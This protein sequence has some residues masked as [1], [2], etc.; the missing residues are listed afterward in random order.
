MPK[1]GA[2]LRNQRKLI[3][4][5][6][7]MDWWFELNRRDVMRSARV[8]VLTLGMMFI[9]G[10]S[11]SQL[12]LEPKPMPRGISYT[13]SWYSPQFE[14]MVLKQGRGQVK[15]TFSYKNGGTLEGQLDGNILKFE[16]SQ[17]SDFSK[18]VRGSSGMGYFVMS[19]DGKKLRGE[20]GYGDEMTGGGAW[21]GE[22]VGENRGSTFDPNAPIFEK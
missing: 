12:V 8:C 18:A 13:G 14:D 7:S 10:C 6:A 5:E 17:E 11:G 20:W 21:N 15:G 3:K 9:F 2:T 1:R 16:W 19:D 4:G 22:R